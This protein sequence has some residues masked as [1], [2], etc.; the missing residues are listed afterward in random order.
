[1]SA[2]AQAREHGFGLGHEGGAAMGLGQPVTPSTGSHF[3]RSLLGGVG[4]TLGAIG[5]Y[6][7]V[8]YLVDKKIDFRAW[9]R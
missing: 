5:V 3:W 1:M 7:L 2:Q 9:K 6:I 4:F 8:D